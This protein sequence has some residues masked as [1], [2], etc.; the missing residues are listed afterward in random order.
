MRELGG[1]LMNADNTET[2]V[3]SEAGIRA[4]QTIKRRFDEGTT[5][6][7]IAASIVYIDSFATGEHSMMIGNQEFPVR[8]GHMNPEMK[9]VARGFMIPTYP[10]TEPAISTTSWAHVVSAQ[11][12]HK[13]EAWRLADFLTANPAYQIELTGVAAQIGLTKYRWYFSLSIRRIGNIRR[14]N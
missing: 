9:G 3:N 6:K 12:K 11:S 4:M 8:F 7:D 13:A 14:K 1:S 10:G 2:L 5:D